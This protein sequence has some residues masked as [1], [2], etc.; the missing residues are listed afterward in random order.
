MPRESVIL[1]VGGEPVAVIDN[2]PEKIE[3]VKEMLKALW[4][5]EKVTVKVISIDDKTE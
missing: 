3:E 4:P 2:I 1:K 5:D